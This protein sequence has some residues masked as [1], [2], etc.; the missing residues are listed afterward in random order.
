MLDTST[1]HLW[2]YAVAGV[3]ILWGKM[4]A[5]DRAVLGLTHMLRVLIPDEWKR[6]RDIVEIVC[7]LSLGCIIS[8]GVLG[9]QTPGQAFAAGLGW[10]SLTT[11]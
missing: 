3:A 4:K 8:M 11:K 1:P 6:L 2:V 7:Y 5:S 9:P 10:A